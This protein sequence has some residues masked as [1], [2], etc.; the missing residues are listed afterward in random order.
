MNIDEL[1]L[2]HKNLE[3]LADGV[4]PKTGYSVEDSILNSSFNKKILKEATEV[5][6]K[7]LKLDYN[8]THND[9]RRKYAFYLSEEDKAKIELS[10]TPIPISAFCYKI[11]EVIDRTKMKQLQ[12]VQI[13]SWLV[14]EGYLREIKSEGGKSFKIL[15]EKSR[16]IGMTSIQ[17]TSSYGN[18]Y[19]V[20]LYSIESQ[21][22]II[23]HLNDIVPR[24]VSVIEKML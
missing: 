2:L 11:N 16:S 7:L 14:K 4:D 22:F 8:P 6:D 5:I 19:D 9:N 21:K 12:A 15:T 20:N 3:L 10:D 13:T 23:A 18:T 17:R 1:I 24:K